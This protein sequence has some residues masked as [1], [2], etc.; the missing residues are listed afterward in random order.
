M[1]KVKGRRALSPQGGAPPDSINDEEQ[2]TTA[3]TVSTIS[4]VNSE[5]KQQDPFRLKPFYLKG[6]DSG[7]F[8]HGDESYLGFRSFECRGDLTLP[9]PNAPTLFKLFFFKRMSAPAPPSCLH[10]WLA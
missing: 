7:A 1:L 5:I 9:S 10:C 4:L 3:D 6:V 2:D 8:E